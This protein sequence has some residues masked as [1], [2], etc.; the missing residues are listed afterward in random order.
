[1]R[2]MSVSFT[3]CRA[4][5]APTEGVR[6][7]GGLARYLH[8][9]LRRRQNDDVAVGEMSM[10]KKGKLMKL[11]ILAAVASVALAA[12]SA[13]AA[14][15]VYVGNWT[16]D[17]GP[18]WRLTPVAY[19]GQ[20]AAAFLFGGSASDYVISTVDNNPFNVDYLSWVSVWHASSFAD[21]SGFPCGRKVAHDSVTSTAGLYLNPGDESALV[22]DWAV[23]DQFRNYAFRVESGVI[24]EPA[25]WGMMIMGFGLVGFAARRRYGRAVHT[26]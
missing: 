12:G 22:E 7:I 25:T 5:G 18:S 2:F 8:G 17:Q 4:G 11:K 1:M 21:C 24:P 3:G 14:T 20:A 10:D 16:V 15:Y 13:D 6:C 26:A 19:T 23:G 9:F